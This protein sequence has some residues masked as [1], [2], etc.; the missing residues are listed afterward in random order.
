MNWELDSTEKL[1]TKF[2]L[3]KNLPDYLLPKINYKRYYPA[4]KYG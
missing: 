1:I 2:N 4:V 3:I